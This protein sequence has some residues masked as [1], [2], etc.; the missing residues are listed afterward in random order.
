MAISDFDAQYSGFGI[1][2]PSGGPQDSGAVVVTATASRTITL[3]VPVLGD[4]TQPTVIR[5]QVAISINAANAGLVLGQIDI[6]TSD[7]TKTVAIDSIPGAI[8]ATAGRGG[9]FTRNVFIDRVDTT[10]IRT[11]SVV[12]TSTGVSTYTAEVRFLYDGQN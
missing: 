8:A 10:T 1:P 3:T 12:I 2:S 5:G 6:S 9:V 4:G 11:L 7:G